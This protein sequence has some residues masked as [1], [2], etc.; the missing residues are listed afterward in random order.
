MKWIKIS[1]FTLIMFISLIIMGESKMLF[2]DSFYSKFDST[3]LYE[4]PKFSNDDM[5]SDIYISASKNNVEIFTVE[6]LNLGN[7]KNKK[8]IYGTPNVE[9]YFN[10][11]ENMYDSVYKSIFSGEIEFEFKELSEN[12]S[13]KY[14]PNFYGIGSHDAIKAFKMDLI[15]KYAGNH[16]IIGDRN[17]NELLIILGIGMLM[18]VVILLFT[19]YEISM[20]KKEI[21][22]R[23]SIGEDLNRYILKTGFIDSLGVFLTFILTYLLIKDLTQVEEYFNILMLIIFIII[24]INWS[25]YSILY[26]SN[27]K[28]AFSN[29][30]QSRKLLT[31]T[32]LFKFFSIV[33]TIFIISSNVVVI[34]QSIS[35]YKQKTFFTNHSDYSTILMEH[36]IDSPK[37]S[38][39]DSLEESERLQ[40]SFYRSYEKKF[41]PIMIIPITNLS[42][43]NQQTLLINSNALPYIKEKIPEL[44]NIKNTKEMKIISFKK[45][46]MNWSSDSLKQTLSSFGLKESYSKKYEELVYNKKS[47]L[48]AIEKNNPIGSKL[49]KN[50]TLI[51]IG[52]R[53]LEK[54]KKMSYILLSNIIYKIEETEFLNYVSKNKMEN[55]LVANNNILVNYE[56]NWNNAK[57]LLILN[58][59]V[60]L[61]IILLE[62]LIMSIILNLEYKVN[63]LELAIK[64]TIGYSIL[65][66]NSKIIFSTI[67][68]TTISCLT[69][70]TI[71]SIFDFNNI[72][73]ISL[74]SILFLILELLIILLLIN[75]IEKINIQKI[76]KGGNI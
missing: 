73:L 75:R 62:L 69:V 50:P 36:K 4:N 74:I 76:L 52:D 7:F 43:P 58:T 31:T 46:S 54:N 23:I 18:M 47:E 24:V 38:E 20:N 28:E 59:I 6:E 12:P 16:P 27:I 26:F 22:I 44:K 29:S 65:Q 15:D 66:K 64:K 14:T 57:R 60:T 68:L 53:S 61:L 55:E 17:N 34:M 8:I 71:L 72:F 9:K 25:L 49:V 42:T 19:M 21:L 48:V 2:L 67:I 51:Y 32:Y 39:S 45:K 3:T 40:T 10:E 41:N 56:F 13:I 11:K 30:I 35:I 5:I 70:I 63:S 33:L 1:V 37:F